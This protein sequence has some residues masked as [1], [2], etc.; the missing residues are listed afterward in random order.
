[1][2]PRTFIITPNLQLDMPSENDSTFEL[3]NKLKNDLGFEEEKITLT[4]EFPDNIP[5]NAELI[6]CLK[7][8]SKNG[9]GKNRGRPDIIG[10]QISGHPKLVILVEVKPKNLGIKVQSISKFQISLSARIIIRN[11]LLIMLSTACFGTCT[12]AVKNSPLSVLL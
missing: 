2:P 5:E 12:T 10:A 11:T 9:K 7:L 1:M 6:E 3:L 4:T 8:A